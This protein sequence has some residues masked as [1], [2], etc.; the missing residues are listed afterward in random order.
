[1]TVSVDMVGRP[2]C[3]IRTVAPDGFTSKEYASRRSVQCYQFYAIEDIAARCRAIFDCASAD[4][5]RRGRKWY[6]SV[7]QICR[8]LAVE[9][10]RP[11]KVV[12]AVVAVLSPRLRWSKNLPAAIA[13]LA[14]EDTFDPLPDNVDKAYRILDGEDVWSVL[15]GNK[16]SRFY[17]NIIGHEEVATL[18]IWMLR[19][20]LGDDSLGDDDYKAITDKVYRTLEQVLVAEAARTGL[21]VAEYQAVLWVVVRGDWE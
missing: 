7:R 9:Y 17:L 8:G 4:D 13:I 5:V 14:G 6:R 15:G 3:D 12:A 10:G 11:F 19:G 2:W 18:D 21:T 16:V 20:M 1:M